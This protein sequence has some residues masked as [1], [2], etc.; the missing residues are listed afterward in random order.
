MRWAEPVRV[1]A[2]A[3]EAYPLVKTGGLADVVG[4]L[5]KALARQGV[6][7]VTMLP[8]YPA[9]LT[10]LGQAREGRL[11]P[12]LF[13]GP[14]RLLGGVAGGIELIAIDAPHL[15][16]RPGG[17]YQDPAGQDFPDNWR[18]FAGLAAA[19]AL[20]AVEGWG[21]EGFAAVHAHD[22]QA[23]LTPAYLRHGRRPLPCLLT[24]HNLAFQGKFDAGIFP[25]LGLPWEAFSPRGV[26]YYGAVGYLK[27]GIWY[28]DA[29]STVS[30]TYAAEIRTPAQGMG[31]D[32]L[33]RGRGDVLHGILN[34]LDTEEWD[35]ATDRYL[36][37]RFSAA[38]VS[39]R[40]GN[41]ALLQRRMGLAEDPAVPLFAYVGRLAWQKGVDLL[42]EAIPAVFAAG[43]QLVILG[44]GEA[45]LAGRCAAA[46]AANRGRIGA[47]IGFSEELA[48]LVYG[49]ADALVLPSRFEPCGL[50]Q[51]CALRYGAVPIVARVG[52]LADTVVDCNIAALGHGWGT[53]FVC[54]PGQP[55][56]L[57]EAILRA[58]ALWRD[59]PSW[60]RIQAHGMAQDVSWEPS[61][62]RYAALL[63]ALISA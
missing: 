61:A 57:G 35:P 10:A 26:E 59:P 25:R 36:P 27:A 45:E 60:R 58:A 19:A 3:S 17:P 30:P 41:K 50:A 29:I 55:E 48:R 51:L 37:Q 56:L 47:H 6:R 21:G 49:G 38:D 32:G 62:A 1:L 22:W 43:G 24:I 39:P 7:V 5:P 8:G 13:G 28:A 33:L 54:A 46:A 15:Y 16:A 63:R 18:R 20:I 52:G 40:A 53:G 31:L 4:A 42:L 2:V 34:G 12:D 14:A 9:V 44:S 23:G 11:I